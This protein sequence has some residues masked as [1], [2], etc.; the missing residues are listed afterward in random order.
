MFRFIASR[1]VHFVAA[2]ETTLS[3][4]V[5]KYLFGQYLRLRAN[6]V[7][8]LKVELS[9]AISLYAKFRKLESL[10]PKTPRDRK[11]HPLR[12][13]VVRNNNVNLDKKNIGRAI[14]FFSTRGRFDKSQATCSFCF[15]DTTRI[16]S[17]LVS[18]SGNISRVLENIVGPWF[19][20]WYRP[21]LVFVLKIRLQNSAIYSRAFFY[22]TRSGIRNTAETR[23]TLHVVTHVRLSFDDE[24]KRTLGIYCIVS[25]CKAKIH[26]GA[27]T[28]RRTDAQKSSAGAARTGGVCGSVG[29]VGGD[30][31]LK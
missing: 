8:A 27:S 25:A 28:V 11:I 4:N 1:T 19:I 22:V 26:A 2:R 16:A 9:I 24:G 31:A 15:V 14:V 23:D 5:R 12:I 17:K 3:P 30:N 18:R 13:Y 6:D 7:A 21:Y 10:S 20:G 29:D